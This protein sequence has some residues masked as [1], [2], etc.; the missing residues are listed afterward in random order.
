MTAFNAAS[1]GQIV[2]G[3]INEGKA[4]DGPERI[5]EG[6]SGNLCRCG[7]YAGITEAVSEPQKNLGA[8]KKAG[9]MKSF[10][11]VRPASVVAAIAARAC[12]ALPIWPPAPI[13]STS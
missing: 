1:A 3:L 2:S 13:C 11:Y 12:R 4:G 5:R 10:D 8:E 7:A 9:R 6:M